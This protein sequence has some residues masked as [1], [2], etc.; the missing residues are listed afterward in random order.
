M[1]ECQITPAT[2]LPPQGTTKRP[3]DSETMRQGISLSTTPGARGPASFSRDSRRL[4]GNDWVRHPI[5]HLF[6][7]RGLGVKG[8]TLENPFTEPSGKHRNRRGSRNQKEAPFLNKIPL[9]GIRLDDPKRT[10]FSKEGKRTHNERTSKCILDKKL[11]L[12]LI[13]WVQKNI[14]RDTSSV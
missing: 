13:F 10:L 8:G 14:G 9:D 5:D 2:L 7:K 12:V 1:S 6:A 4:G 3:S 11:H